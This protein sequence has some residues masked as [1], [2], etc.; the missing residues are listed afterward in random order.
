[1]LGDRPI[2]A[3]D[4]LYAVIAAAN[5]DP[6]RYSCPG[7]LDLESGQQKSHLGFGIGPRFC[8]GASLA[9]AEAQELV[10]G[11]A[12]RFSQL[13]FDSELG[14]AHLVGFHIRSFRPLYAS[15]VERL[16]DIPGYIWDPARQ[17]S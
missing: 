10:T 2:A 6:G 5:R 7:E 4:R 16:D 17:H 12:D 9:R 1:M 3:G 14:A 13:T 11:M 15:Y 8:I